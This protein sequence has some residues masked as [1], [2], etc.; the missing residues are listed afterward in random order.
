MRVA[1]RYA[2]HGAWRAAGWLDCEGWPLEVHRV[3]A[4]T[5]IHLRRQEGRRRRR[6]RRRCGSTSSHSRRHSVRSHPHETGST[7][8]CTS[9]DLAAVTKRPARRSGR[10][11]AWRRSG[12]RSFSRGSS[13][14]AFRYRLTGSASIPRPTGGK[15]SCGLARRQPGAAH[16]EILRRAA[17][18]LRMTS[19]QRICGRCHLERSERSQPRGC[20]RSSA[21]RDPSSRFG[22]TRDD[23]PFLSSAGR[24]RARH[25]ATRSDSASGPDKDWPECCRRTRAEPG[26]PAV[27]SGSIRSCVSFRLR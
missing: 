18:R 26:S 19:C 23:M 7:D 17:A 14:R 13:V 10:P 5:E 3:T 16:P 15:Y 8:V 24:R 12:L 11:G 9:A 25:S 22:A 1:R 2:V 21:S 27:A 20:S 4:A 6:Y